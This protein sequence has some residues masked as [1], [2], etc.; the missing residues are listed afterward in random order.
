MN[1]N[2]KNPFNI[3]QLN[4]QNDFKNFHTISKNLLFS[5]VPF[6]KVVELLFEKSNPFIVKFKT[7]SHGFSDYE[8]VNIF[9]MDNS[10]KITL[11]SIKNPPIVRALKNNKLGLA[12]ISDVQS[13][14]K[15]MPVSDKEFY[16][17]VFAKY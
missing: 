9:P 16:E 4:N 10:N 11:E 1:V 6:L 8:S 17:A 3:L 12:K 2:K 14:Y 7:L 5:K 13:L 15:F